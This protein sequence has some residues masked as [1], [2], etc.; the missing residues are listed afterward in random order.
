MKGALPR[1]FPA[2]GPAFVP[3]RTRSQPRPEPEKPQV[4]SGDPCTAAARFAQAAVFVA[5]C[6]LRSDSKCSGRRSESGF[7]W[8]SALSLGDLAMAGAP[9]GRSVRPPARSVRERV[10]PRKLEGADRAWTEMATLE[11][12]DAFA[13]TCEQPGLGRQAEY[14]VNPWKLTYSWHQ[15]NFSN[16]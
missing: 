8:P 9:S 5:D 2:P 12:R 11:F 6:C 7:S 15:R 16:Y 1:S 3:R 13:L 4:K 14:S 10:G